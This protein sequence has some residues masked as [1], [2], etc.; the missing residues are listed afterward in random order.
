IV[1]LVG[2]RFREQAPATAV[3]SYRVDNQDPPSGGYLLAPQTE[4]S[5]LAFSDGSKV[6]MAARARGRVVEVS[7]RGARFALDAG[8]AS[9]DIVPRPR[10]Q[11]SFEAGP[12]RVSV[13]GTSFTIAWSPV[14]AVFEVHLASGAISVASPVAGPEIQMR[15]GQTLRV[16][17][18]D[19]SSTLGSL[20]REVPSPAESAPAANSSEPPRTAPNGP[21]E[22]PRWSHRGWMSALSQNRAADILADAERRGPTSVIERADSDDL[23]AL[24]NAARYAGRHALAG[25]ALNAHR[26]RFPSSERSREAA[27]LLGRLHDGDSDPSEALGWYDRYLVE[28]HDG[29]GVA[30]ALGRKM[31]LL[32]RS[33][34]RAEALAVAREYLRRSPRGTYANAARALVR[35][36]T[37]GQ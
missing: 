23:W 29:V 21:P 1:G 34:R 27:F 3:L 14:D 30:D 24:A 5:L 9:V 17:L 31:T 25:Q 33:N 6:K 32:E 18:R 4:E 20:G 26:R 13:H 28:A 22:P 15:A 16:S 19:Q 2:S 7:S 10:A 12:F 11:W 8:Q 37:A 36:S 35:S